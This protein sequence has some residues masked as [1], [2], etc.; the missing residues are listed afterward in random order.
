MECPLPFIYFF[1]S[2]NSTVIPDDDSIVHRLTSLASRSS[3]KA[4]APSEYILHISFSLSFTVTRTPVVF[5]ALRNFV[6]VISFLLSDSQ[7]GNTYQNTYKR[8]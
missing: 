5:K 2:A 7:R 6:K 4:S 3:A 8:S 1:Y